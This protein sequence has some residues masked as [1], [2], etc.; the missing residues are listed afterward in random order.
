MS[1]VGKGHYNRLNQLQQSMRTS[2]CT[3][4]WHLY[5]PSWPLYRIMQ[6]HPP[7]YDNSMSL[8]V[9]LYVGWQDMEGGGAPVGGCAKRELVHTCLKALPLVAVC[10]SIAFNYTRI[11]DVER[12]LRELQMQVGPC[13]ADPRQGRAAAMDAAAGWGSHMHIAPRHSLRLSTPQQESSMCPRSHQGACTQAK[14][15][16]QCDCGVY[17][18]WGALLLVHCCV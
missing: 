9:T 12:E 7:R 13:T 15:H 17:W 2:Q 14:S 5:L 8:L 4:C 1:R 11:K 18:A 16:A 3:A 10:R 6:G